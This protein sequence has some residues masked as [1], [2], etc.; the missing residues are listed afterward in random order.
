MLLFSV[1]YGMYVYVI[2]ICG[3][4]ILFGKM[5]ECLE[6]KNI[7]IYTENH[8]KLWKAFSFLKFLI[9]EMLMKKQIISSSYGFIL[10]TLFFA[11]TIENYQI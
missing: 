9:R 11:H 1:V 8:Q 3:L 10:Q 2:E 4:S 7:K 6:H 5:Y